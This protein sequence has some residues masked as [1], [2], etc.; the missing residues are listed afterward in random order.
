[1]QTAPAF[2]AQNVHKAFG[3]RTVLEDLS[4]AVAA[5]QIVGLI[6]SNG[7]GKTTLL[8]VL[9]GLLPADSG[10]A[11]IAGEKSDALSPAL[12]ARIGYVPQ[13][14]TQFAWLNGRSMLRYVA[15][16]YPSFDW[17]YA[18]ELIER[19][20]VSVK[21]PI[22]LL[23]PGQ[24][25]RLSIVRALAS[26]PDLLVLDEPMASL[27]PSTRLAVIEELAR[28]R[29][30]RPI[31][32]IFSSHITQDLRRLCTHFVILAKGTVALQ[33]SVGRCEQLT[34]L[35]LAGDEH[36]LSAMD[37]QNMLL[38]RAERDGERRVVLDQAAALQLAGAL[39]PS[40]RIRDRSDDL[41]A[42]LAE[43]MA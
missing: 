24:Q 40:C 34:T 38:V 23:S 41:D 10:T 8:K 1:M 3:S 30:R 6:G 26:R 15:A 4:L 16:F 12:R 29:E 36:A 5:G 11:L 13:S 43:W 19:W 42:T 14:S 31:S 20:K 2:S 9:L 32:M 7:A 37:Q 17:G 22:G 28:E 27:D 39:P 21:T 18:R 35:I 25:Q 33:E